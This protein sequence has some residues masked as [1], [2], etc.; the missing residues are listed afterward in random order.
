M[1]AQECPYYLSIGMTWDQYWYGDVRM[2]WA[3]REAHN[4]RLEQQNQMLW[5]QGQYFYSVL[6]SFVPVLV[7]VPKKNAKVLPY[8][9]L[10]PLFPK[11]PTPEELE[12]QEKQESLRA[13]LYMRQMVQAGKNWGG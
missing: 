10:R 4:L 3:L 9:E 1:F 5:L 6:G 12:E 7:T 13:E 11:G 8:P 2:T